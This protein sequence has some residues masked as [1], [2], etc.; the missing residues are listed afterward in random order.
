M[1][2]HSFI[3]SGN[4]KIV[5]QTRQFRL[6]TYTNGNETGM[7]IEALLGFWD[8]D[9]RSWHSRETEEETR[10][11]IK[12]VKK[13]LKPICLRIGVGDPLLFCSQ[14]TPKNGNRRGGGVAHEDGKYRSIRIRCHS[15]KRWK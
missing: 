8:Q 7:M 13:V 11:Q 6:P 12:D 15:I 14:P 10:Y 1:A 9:N 5:I 4:Q 2:Q 3:Q